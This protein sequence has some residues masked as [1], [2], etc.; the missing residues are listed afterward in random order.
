M[1]DTRSRSRSRRPSSGAL[2]VAKDKRYVL[3]GPS[4]GSLAVTKDRDNTKSKTE[5]CAFHWSRPVPYYLELTNCAGRRQ[6]ALAVAQDDAAFHH[7][8]SGDL[9]L[10]PL[11]AAYSTLNLRHDREGNGVSWGWRARAVCEG[12]VRKRRV[13]KHSNIKCTLSRF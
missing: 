6:F 3:S 12:G 10:F 13:G 1:K 8:A 9:G 2:A 7:R 5:S 4:P 11:C